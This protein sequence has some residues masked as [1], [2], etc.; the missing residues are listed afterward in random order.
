M[1]LRKGG[2]RAGGVDEG[3]QGS[4]HPGLLSSW[5]IPLYE[6]LW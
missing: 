5:A 3:K 2:G 4:T 6:A 1:N